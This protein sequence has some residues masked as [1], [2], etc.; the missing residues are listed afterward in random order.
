LTK[1]YLVVPHPLSIKFISGE[2]SLKAGEGITRLLGSIAVAVL[3]FYLGVA[4]ARHP[5]GLAG[6][7]LGS[8]NE[9]SQQLKTRSPPEARVYFLHDN[10]SI[11]AEAEST[12]NLLIKR[13]TFRNRGIVVIVIGHTDTT[14]TKE[15]NL[16]LSYDRAKMVKKFLAARGIPSTNIIVL[17]KGEENLPFPT[18][19]ETPSFFNRVTEIMI[20]HPN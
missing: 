15:Y 16:T 7:S 20:K 14:G 19:D 9:I 6:S 1:P 8:R 13:Q 18:P 3:T 10:Y 17:G 2:S 11:T 4:F 12:L 5:Q